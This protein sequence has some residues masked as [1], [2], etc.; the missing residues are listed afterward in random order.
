[1]PAIALR[2]FKAAIYPLLAANLV[3]YLLLGRASEVLDAAAWIALLALFEVETAHGE[4]L[5][6][7]QVRLIHVL[8][9]AASA[10]VMA[11]AVVYV[12]EEEWLDAANAWLW[13]AVVALLEVE[14]RHPQ[15][16]ARR[17]GAFVAATAVLYAA[18]LALVPA[19]A[20][21]SA[22]LNAWDATLWLAAFFV[23]ELNVLA[24]RTGYPVQS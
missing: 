16:V 4:R 14:V 19:W 20:W 10:G 15:A 5:S 9:L 17:R 8:R 21:Q 3:L 18:L 2:R 13:L 23:I 7:P 1:M 11:A 24:P 12:I 22:W 6:A